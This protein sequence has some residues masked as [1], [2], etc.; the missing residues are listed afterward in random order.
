MVRHMIRL[1]PGQHDIVTR[2][3][4]QM[5]PAVNRRPDVLA[6][7]SGKD[8]AI[9]G[10]RD[11]KFRRTEFIAMPVPIIPIR[12]QTAHRRVRQKAALADATPVRGLFARRYTAGAAAVAVIA[13]AFAFALM[14]GLP[15]QAGSLADRFG[16][17]TPKAQIRVDHSA[18]R[19][20]L[21]AYLRTDSSGLNRFAYRRV[22]A[23]DRARLKRYIARLQQV[24]PARL[25]RNEQMAFWINFYNA[26]TVDVILAHYPVRSIR[27][28]GISPG[29][30][31]KGPWRKK[32]VRVAGVAL[33]LDDIEHE[34]LRKIWRDK[35]IHYAV[36]CASVG[37][38]NLA[39]KPYTGATLESMLNQAARDYINNPRG[40]RIEG[41]RLVLSKLYKWYH[42]D[43]GTKQELLRHLRSYAAAP[44]AR[45]LTGDIAIASYQY[46]WR[47]NE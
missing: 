41:G 32:L 12:H 10:L 45:H 34:I 24:R 46:D 35:R 27:D 3:W 17:A 38:P 23:G 2:R 28:I 5:R 4:L 9:V 7:I 11:F 44:L 37:C 39:R 1:G 15:A 33:S 47:L 20:L 36:N 43:F 21:K 14:A 8:N 16:V 22:S 13:F 6:E 42:G 29:L 30:F 25:S 40:V 31:T 18:W 26:L 19:D